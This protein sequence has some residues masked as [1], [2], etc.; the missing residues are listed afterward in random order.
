MTDAR[1]TTAED[2]QDPGRLSARARKTIA[3]AT[4]IG[5][6]ALGAV[7]WLFGPGGDKLVAPAGVTS[8]PSIDGT[9]AEVGGDRLVLKAFRPLGGRNEVTFTI[10][11]RDRRHF[12]LAHLRSHSSIALPTRLYY[13]RQGERLFA[14]YKED[15][16][17]NSRREAQR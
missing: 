4:A 16:P 12:D 6:L 10:R 3:L 11:S 5:L 8:L 7:G 15:A 1:T 9:L 14:V 13:E 2:S 17:A